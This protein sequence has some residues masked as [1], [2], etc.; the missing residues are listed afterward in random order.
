MQNV[1]A[2]LPSKLSYAL[3]YK[4]QRHWGALRSP[5]HLLG[6]HI[7]I[8]TWQQLVSSGYDPRQKTFFEVGTGRKPIT[9]LAFWL[10]GAERVYTLDVNPYLSEEL[11][12]EAVM[13]I[14]SRPDEVINMMGDFI[15]ERRLK[16]LIEFCSN[17]TFDLTEFLAFACIECYAPADAA[18]TTLPDGAIDVHTSYTVFEHIP[19][20]IIRDIMTEAHRLLNRG[21]VAVHLIDYTDH[22]CHKD[23][24]IHWLNFLRYS[25]QS[26]KVLF[27]NRYMYMNRLRHDDQLAIGQAA[28]FSPVTLQTELDRK[29]PEDIANGTIKLAPRFRAKSLDVLSIVNAWVLYR[30]DFGPS[31]ST[32]TAST[33]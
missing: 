31:S 1:I 10:M 19:A 23:S 13:Q 17:G 28:G 32:K 33:P 22:F 18:H 2:L 8:E 5:N 12:I 30:P 21:G 24:S 9:P 27:G 29:V 25:D 14:S 11:T 7:G 6:L 16:S 15:N 26:C 4:A 20:P 3:Y